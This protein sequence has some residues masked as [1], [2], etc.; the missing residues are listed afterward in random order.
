MSVQN[1]TTPA[2]LTEALEILKEGNGASRVTAG[3]TD[4]FL[5]LEKKKKTADTLVDVRKIPELRKIEK[6]GDVLYIGGAMTH[7]EVENDPLVKEYFAALSKGASVVGGPQIRNVGTIAGNVVN[8]QPAADT[9]VPLFAFDAA[10]VVASVDGTVS[11]TPIAAL[12]AGPGKSTLDA[13][14]NILVGFKLPLGKYSVS[15]FA[16]EGKRNA[17]TL[18]MLNLAAA[19]KLENGVI[20]EAS[21][22]AGPVSTTPFRLTDAETFLKGKTPSAELF[23]EAGKLAEAQANPRD[24]LLRGGASFRKELLHYMVRDLLTELAL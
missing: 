12:Y 9:A 23:D 22:A 10:A 20:A 21:L 15:G 14:K 3:A 16:R 24:S 13:T 17:L 18:P 7:T 4:M 1:Y 19:L 11:E 8:A 2:S 6:Q 5:D